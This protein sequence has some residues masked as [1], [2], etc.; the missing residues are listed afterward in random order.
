MLVVKYCCVRDGKVVTSVV[1]NDR[2]GVWRYQRCELFNLDDDVDDALFDNEPFQPEE[3]DFCVMEISVGMYII[4]AES[5]YSV[6]KLQCVYVI[7]QEV[8]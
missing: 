4:F 2:R 8:K 7:F 5:N 1:L 3:F 6:R